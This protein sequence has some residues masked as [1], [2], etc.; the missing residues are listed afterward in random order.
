MENR[1][2]DSLCKLIIYDGFDLFMTIPKC[3][4]HVKNNIIY[5]KL[6]N[7]FKNGCEKIYLIFDNEEM[8]N[9]IIKQ[10]YYKKKKK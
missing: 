5:N 6:N 2:D 10:K 4:I 8:K 1:K 3:K 9:K 7:K